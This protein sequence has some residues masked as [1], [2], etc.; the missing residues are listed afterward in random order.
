MHCFVT[1]EAFGRG[2]PYLQQTGLGDVHCGDYEL[3]RVALCPPFSSL[4][5]AVFGLSLAIFHSIFKGSAF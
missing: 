2:F 1:R 5:I 3:T 4:L